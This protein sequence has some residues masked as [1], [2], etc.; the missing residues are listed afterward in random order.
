MVKYR[1]DRKAGKWGGAVSNVEDMQA[2][3]ETSSIEVVE[4]I[5]PAANVFSTVQ[6]DS[7]IDLYSVG[8]EEVTRVMCNNG[9]EVPFQNTL[10]LLTSG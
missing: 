2:A 6:N 4:V 1:V 3:R 5:S 7:I 8:H 10:H 9:V